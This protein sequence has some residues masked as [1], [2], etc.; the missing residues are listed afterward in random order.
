M[1]F[2]YAIEHLGW[3][4][5]KMQPRHL[6]RVCYK[7]LVVTVNVIPHICRALFFSIHIS[8]HIYS[9]CIF[10]F[11]D[12]R[13]YTNV[14]EFYLSLSVSMMGLFTFMFFLYFFPLYLQPKTNEILHLNLHERKISMSD[15]KH[16]YL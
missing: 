11:N 12:S 7:L 8:L 3:F 16:S 13:F 15:L 5:V 4:C 9:T 14:K 1:P 10:Y 6:F 2:I